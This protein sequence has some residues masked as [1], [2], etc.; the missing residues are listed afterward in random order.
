MKLITRLEWDEAR[1]A[2]DGSKLKINEMMEQFLADAG[3]LSNVI[4]HGKL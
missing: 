1:D 4:W 3:K 2:C